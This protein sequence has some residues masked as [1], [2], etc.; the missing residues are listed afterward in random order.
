VAAKCEYIFSDFLLIYK[1]V[2]GRL[3]SLANAYNSIGL[4]KFKKISLMTQIKAGRYA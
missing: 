2:K 3:V 1:L 4:N